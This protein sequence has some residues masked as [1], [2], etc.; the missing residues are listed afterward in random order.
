MKKIKN[1]FLQIYNDRKQLLFLSFLTFI[2]YLTKD[3]FPTE[4]GVSQATFAVVAIV[5]L[6]I[7][8]AAG[9]T[10]LI[11]ASSGK[12]KRIAEQKKAKAEMNKNMRRYK[13]LDTSNLQAG[14]RN[15]YLDIENV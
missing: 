6:G 3:L 5:G 9:I 12:K 1:I 7:M 11:I 15:K 14:V 8:A 10:N 13:N 4:P 2:S